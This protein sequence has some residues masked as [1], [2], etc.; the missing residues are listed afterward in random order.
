MTLSYRDQNRGERGIRVQVWVRGRGGQA[1]GDGRTPLYGGGDRLGGRVLL[2]VLER[3]RATQGRHRSTGDVAADRPA[4]VPGP[5]AH[6]VAGDRRRPGR[7]RPAG[8]RAGAGHPRLR[9]A[10]ARD[11]P[12]LLVGARRAGGH[13]PAPPGR[14]RLGRG[15]HGQLVHLPGRVRTQR[16]R[17]PARPAQL[18]APPGRG[19]GAGAG[20]TCPQP[21]PHRRVPGRGHGRGGGHGL[22]GQLHADEELRPPPERRR[23]G[24]HAGPPLGALRPGRGGGRR[25]PD[26]AERLPGGGPARRP[27]LPRGV[28]AGG[29]QRARPHV[30]ARA[31]ARHRRTDQG[32][33]RGGH[34]VDGGQRLV[35]GPV[36]GRRTSGWRAGARPG[37][38]T[39]TPCPGRPGAP[40]RPVQTHPSST[41]V[42]TGPVRSP[43]QT[44]RRPRHAAQRTAAGAGRHGT[45]RARLRAR[46]RPR[47]RRLPPEQIVDRGWGRRGRSRR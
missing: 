25:V 38:A 43:C 9:P 21:T 36:G 42:R 39:S 34:R 8:P 47:R 44:R 13:R 7:V 23:R 11:Q 24:R 22:R 20:R 18:G 5:P 31:P 4:L 12:A 27:A 10:P 41:G 15:V 37:V 14:H 1:G 19:G 2:R 17:R 32:G 40:W 28:R 6:L 29:G 33:G 45:A 35:V 26:P 16:R 3:H 46:V 30:D